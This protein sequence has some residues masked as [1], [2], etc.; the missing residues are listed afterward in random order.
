MALER[1][2]ERAELVEMRERGHEIGGRK[3][4]CHGAGMDNEMNK[5]TSN[6]LVL[7]A[8]SLVFRNSSKPINQ[9]E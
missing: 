2:Q 5:A 4:V 6:R 9:T 8:W 3:D 7:L 1:G